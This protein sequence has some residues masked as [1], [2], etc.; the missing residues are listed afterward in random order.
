[1]GSMLLLLARVAV[2]GVYPKARE[3]PP[4]SPQILEGLGPLPSPFPPL[5][6]PRGT[7]DFPGTDHHYGA[8]G[9]RE[10]TSVVRRAFQPS[11]AACK[12]GQKNSADPEQGQDYG[13][14]REDAA[15]MR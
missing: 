4:P 11:L 1:L 5:E 12:T 8:A 2:L 6:S 9:R 3:A 7:P 14:A 10:V 13:G 15:R